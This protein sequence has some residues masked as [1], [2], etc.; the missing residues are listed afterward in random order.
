ME[1][2]LFPILDNKTNFIHILLY[3]D[4]YSRY[5]RAKLSKYYFPNPLD[6]EYFF[7]V[8]CSIDYILRE[9]KTREVRYGLKMY[10]H[11]K[12]E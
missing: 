6:Y 3:S 7:W 10:F 11:F 8:P 2:Q 5:T 9:K 12:N 4:T 1:I